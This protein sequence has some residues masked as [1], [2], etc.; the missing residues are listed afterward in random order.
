MSGDKTDNSLLTAGLM[1][2]F[3][4]G[5]KGKLSYSLTHTQLHN[6]VALN[7]NN[8]NESAFG[9]ELSQSL[10]RNL[11]GSETKAQAELL[12]EQTEIQ[13]Y[14]ESFKIKNILASAESLY[15]GLSQT[16]KL[17][18]VQKENLER[19]IKI[20][21]WTQGRQSSGLGEKSDFLQADANVKFRE[22]ELKSALQDEKSLQRSFNSLRGIEGDLVSETLKP[23]DNNFIKLLSPPKKA[24][25]RDDTKAARAAN[26]LSKANAELSI[27][28]NKPNLEIYGNYILNGRDASRSVA[29][30]KTFTKD[31]STQALG[32]R[33]SAP[34]DYFNLQNNID[35][36]KQDQ[37]ASDLNFKQKLFD[38]TR[39]WTDLTNKFE[40]AKIKLILA[41]KI[42]EAQRVKVI[43]ERERLTKGRT[44]TF[45]VLNFEQDFAQ[46]EL[47][48]IKSETDILNLYS[49]LKIFSTNNMTGD[50]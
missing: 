23:V 47:L 33:F 35:G 20:K 8:F 1:E 42:E 14:S 6:A 11:W 45:Q 19:A 39:E 10:W 28:R 21:S 40:D 7:P 37:I 25:L 9:L 17:I 34:L 5:L 26:K 13:K 49:Q 29:V 36:Y 44:V 50:K 38:E 31:Y 22:F 4:F 32:V 30:D 2:Q 27:E 12:V 3:D 43:N 16:R 18:Q 48:K 24:E 15:W 41:E 46:S